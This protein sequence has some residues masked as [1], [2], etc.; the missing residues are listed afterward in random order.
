MHVSELYIHPLKSARGIPVK[1]ITLD[2][3]GP[4]GDR[5]WM[6]ID[7]AGLMVSQRDYPRMALIGA[8]RNGDG[9]ICTAPGMP[10]LHARTPRTGETPRLNAIVW[11]NEVDVQLAS[12]EAHTWFSQFLGGPCRLVH[13]PDDA[14][15]QVNRVY[16]PKGAGVSLA[17]GYPLLLTGQGSL[18]DLNSRLESP[19][20]M[21]RF[22]PNLVVFGSGP[23][24]ED[25][26][27]EIRA[28]EI[29]FSLVKPCARC[30]IPTVDPDTGVM[31]KE[32]MRTLATY[33]RRG[34]D[35]FFGWNLLP[36]SLGTIHV[37]DPV[38]VLA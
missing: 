31:G 22:R 34:S 27:R 24:E 6:L 29:T 38:E 28:G 7:P 30:P 13:Q 19:I 15:R 5:R 11:D 23:F 14:F 8:E 20:D 1:E 35:I 32:P 18:D 9:L 37:G 26:W 3:R 33:R 16:A 12:D 36:R 25:T 4:A 10:P 2:D 17:D 21:R